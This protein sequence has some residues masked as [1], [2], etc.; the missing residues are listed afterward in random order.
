MK[1][2]N[3]VILVIVVCITM[4]E[5]IALIMGVDGQFFAT[6]IAALFGLGGLGSGFQLHKHKTK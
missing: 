3:I 6:S 4:L 5:G 2:A 1:Q